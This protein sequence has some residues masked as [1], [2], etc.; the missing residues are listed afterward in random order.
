MKDYLGER[1]FVIPGACPPKGS[2][3]PVRKGSDKTRESSKRVEPWTENAVRV[4]RLQLGTAP[5]FEGPVYV[6]ATFAFESPAVTESEYPVAPT[7]GDTDKLLRCLNDA[8]TKAGVIEDDRFVVHT[9][10]DK[11][12]ADGSFTVA[13]VGRAMRNATRLETNDNSSYERELIEVTSDLAS[14]QR[15]FIPGAVAWPMP[16]PN[17]YGD[18]VDHHECMLVT[19]PCA[20]PGCPVYVPPS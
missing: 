5:R 9:E 19:M 6:R 17:P 4:L 3:V 7:I 12:W 1:S 11:V 8:L 14:G 2:R 16:A 20:D 18:F 13:L 10:A 15:S